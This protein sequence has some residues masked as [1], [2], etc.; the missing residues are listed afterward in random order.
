LNGQD[1]TL[2]VAADSPVDELK[3]K[4]IELE[5][6]FS[7]VDDILNRL[8][9]SKYSDDIKDIGGSCIFHLKFVRNED[10]V[11]IGMNET[12]RAKLL[13]ALELTL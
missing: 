3:I 5:T 11:E 8:N 9:L 4:I 1:I 2:Y 13:R 6:S 7:N 10:L 12:E